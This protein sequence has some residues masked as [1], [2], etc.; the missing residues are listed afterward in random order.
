MKEKIPFKPILITISALFLVYTI[1]GFF[2]VPVGIKKALEKAVDNALA[3]K[4][5]AESVRFNPYTLEGRIQNL[6]IRTRENAALMAVDEVYVNISVAS[7]F[8]L[9]PV[10]DAVSIDGPKITLATDA[11][12][13]LNGIPAGK[14]KDEKT[15]KQAAGLFGFRLANLAVSRGEVAFTDGSRKVAHHIKEFSLKVPLVST[16]EDEMEQPVSANAELVL[17]DAGI[18]M[19]ASVRPFGPDIKG[20]VHVQGSGVNLKSYLSY[21]PLPG[22]LALTAPGI[23]SWDLDIGAELPEKGDLTQAGISVKGRAGI[24]DLAADLREKG[25]LAR[26]AGVTVN[27]DTKDLMSQGFK[28]DLIRINQPELFLERDGSGAFPAMAL[29][30]TKE[31]QEEKPAPEKNAFSLT[32]ALDKAEVTDG[33]VHIKDGVPETG[34]E[35]LLSPVSIQVENLKLQGESLGLNAAGTLVTAAGE[36][37][38]LAASLSRTREETLIN[39]HIGLENG[40]PGAY[41]AYLSPLTKDRVALDKIN[42]ASD[43]SLG[44]GVDGLRV[45]TSSGVLALAGF[46]FGPPKG[47]PIINLPDASVNGIALDLDQ[48]QV[49]IGSMAAA[50]GTL[51]VGMDPKGRVNLVEELAPLT[52]NTGTPAP[53]T[54]PGPAWQISLGEFGMDG[55][56]VSFKDDSHGAN[57]VRVSL[58]DIRLHAKDLT[59]APK[60]AP[61]KITGGMKIQDSGRFNMAGT[62]DLSRRK[63][64]LGLKLDGIGINIFEPYF[65]DYLKIE[66]TDGKFGADT[67]LSLAFPEGKKPG[68]A[69]SGKAGVSDFSSKDKATR[70]DFFRCKSLF[71]SGMDISLWPVKVGIK[72]VSLTDFYSRALLSEEGQLNLKTILADSEAEPSGE[73]EKK[74]KTEPKDSNAPVTQMPAINISNI[75]L[76]GGHINFTDQF[77]KPNYTANMTQVGGRITNLSSTSADPADLVLKGVHGLYSPLDIT[78]KLRPFG[79]DRMADVNLSFKNIDLTQF[80]AY[81]QKYLG[82][83]ID[84]GKLVLTLEYHIKG[85]QLA[86]SNRLFFDQFNLGQKVESETATGLPIQLAISLLKNSKDQIDLDIPVKGD[87]NDP[88]FSFAGVVGTAFKNLILSV[89]KAPFKLLGKVFGMFD[90]GELGY[91]EFDPGRDRLDDEAK[92]KLDHLAKALFEKK[93]LKFIIEGRY[94]ADLDAGVLRTAKYRSALL[95]LVKDKKEEKQEAILQDPEKRLE[96]AE[97]LYAAADFPKPRDEKGNEKQISPEEMEKLLLTNTAVTKDELADLAA[98]RGALIMEYLAAAGPLDPQRLFLQSPG[99][100]TDEDRSGQKVK[101]VFQIE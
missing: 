52:E 15:D 76:Q 30:N 66:I 17:N 64:R 4:F 70:N 100:A 82:Y 75:T 3:G 28:V 45:K 20:M 94:D 32:L 6:D 35:T 53:E 1:A 91:V 50:K 21:V 26:I 63:A 51:A 8:K 80:N 85:G 77:T 5:S 16:F 10:I 60:A 54:E 34:F 61:G 81:A 86:S 101:T 38:T 43:F 12:G 93:T 58:S 57:P 22:A 11:S 96:L 19:D 68:L 55:W 46:R 42:A 98:R 97:Q 33:K 79:S 62:L 47:T 9:A 23:L 18:R 87:L 29:A 67:T 99:P 59:T 37:L 56:Q 25:P 84:T 71:V 40:S 78:G 92:N 13:K 83:G 31:Q 72:D 7:L 27:I 95:A 36:T 74:P 89:V 90:S 65:T 88:S 69:L 14:D 2:L 44:L 73:T 39:G 48:R 24:K 41:G 49:S